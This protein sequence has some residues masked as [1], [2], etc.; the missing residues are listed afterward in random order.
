MVISEKLDFNERGIYMPRNRSLDLRLKKEINKHFISI[1]FPSYKFVRA[2]TSK[3]RVK[4]I[5]KIYN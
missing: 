3:N 4:L 5:Y 2:E 1:G